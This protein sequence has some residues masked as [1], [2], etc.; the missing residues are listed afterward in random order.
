M[1]LKSIF[2]TKSKNTYDKYDINYTYY[3]FYIIYK[4]P[5]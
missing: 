3:N 5:C 4:E 2:N 1:R